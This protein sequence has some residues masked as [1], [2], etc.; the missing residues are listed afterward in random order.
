MKR[1]DWY[2]VAVGQVNMAVAQDGLVTAKNE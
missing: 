2:G 1:D